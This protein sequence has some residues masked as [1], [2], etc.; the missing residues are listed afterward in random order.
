MKSFTAT[1]P[2]IFKAY[3]GA[4]TGYVLKRRTVTYV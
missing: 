1:L 3:S 4:Y 2:K